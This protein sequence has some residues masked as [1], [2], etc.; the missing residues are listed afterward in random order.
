MDIL[1]PK[2]AEKGLDLLCDLDA[3]VPAL[4]KGDP[5]RM[6]QVFLNLVN[7]AVKFTDRGRWCCGF[8]C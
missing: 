1:G 3:K 8:A 7:N 6:R 5:G 2:A 4:V